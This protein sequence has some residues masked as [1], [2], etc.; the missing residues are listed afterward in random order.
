MKLNNIIKGLADIKQEQ[1]EDKSSRRSIL[2][3]VGAKVAVAAIPLGAATLAPSSA[4]AQSK[5][6]LINVL[7][8][9]LKLE[10]I[11]ARFYDQSLNGS[12]AVAIPEQLREQVTAVQTHVTAH[13]QMLKD[14]ILVL[15]GTADT[16]DDSKIDLTGGEGEGSGPFRNAFNTLADYLVLMTYLSDAST[17]I[18]KGQITEVLSDKDVI[19]VIANIHTVK[20]RHATLARYMRSFYGPES[21]LP[22]ITKNNSDTV[23]AGAQRAYAGEG[24]VEQAGISIV[25]INGYDIRQNHA[26]QAFDEPIDIINGNDILDRFLDLS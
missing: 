9:L 14:M 2:K 11:N 16:I 12:N 1:L 8:Y 7:N 3:K 17:R 18:Y 25:G 5:E 6:T 23:N 15:G 19:R 4:K 10:Y 20:A 21:A 13:I 26:T 22:W 24:E